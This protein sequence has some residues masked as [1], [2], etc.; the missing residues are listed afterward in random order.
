MTEKLLNTLPPGYREKALKNYKE[1][2]GMENSKNLASAIYCLIWEDWQFWEGLYLWAKNQ[3]E[4]PIL[5]NEN[6]N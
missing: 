3:G 6:G 5:K 2:G 4:L 1:N